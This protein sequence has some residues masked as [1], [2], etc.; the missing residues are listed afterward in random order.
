MFL[1]RLL[2][3]CG[4]ALFHLPQAFA[5][6]SP[7]PRATVRAKTTPAPRT[8]ER[9]KTTPE[10][11][12]DD[13]PRAIPPA[14]P[15]GSGP[16]VTFNSVYVEEPY[17]AMTFDDGPHATLTPKLLDM[18]AARRLKATFFVIGQNAV[19][20]PQIMKRI[21]QEG[22]ELANHSWSHPNLGKMGDEG[23][24]DQLRKTDEAIKAAA[25]SRTTLMRPPYGS[26]TPRQKQWMHQEFGYK[27]IIWDVDPFDW[28]RPGPG[29][30]RDRIVNQARPGSI[31]LAHDIHPGTVEAMPATFDGLMAK[32]FKFATVSELLAMA[33][34]PPP[35]PKPSAT[36]AARP[37]GTAAPASPAG[38][39]PATPAPPV[40]STPPASAAPAAPAVPGGAP[41]GTPPP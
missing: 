30:I 12:A 19:E 3:F 31:I 25:G 21:V 7:A 33:K 41:A 22:H 36:P 2:L 1:T 29:V 23:V 10:P 20:Y 5:Q 35:K 8:A 27:T 37:P 26:I 4:L 38:P 28:K 32:G 39:A 13:Q 6:S 15:A 9:V 11:V 14:P 40:S 18:L 16:Q 34:T 17:I 24:R